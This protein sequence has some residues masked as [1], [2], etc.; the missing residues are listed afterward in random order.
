MAAVQLA[1]ADDALGLGADVDE[2]LVLVD[3]DDVAFD[4]VA[5]FEALDVLALLGEKLLHR[6]RLGPEIARRGGLVWSLLLLGSGWGIVGLGGR[7]LGRCLV[8]SSLDGRS[9]AWSGLVGGCLDGSGLV[10]G[11]LDG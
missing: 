8:G 1:V 6:G 10:G 4:D 11:C 3:T 2:D 9:L 5:M 7:R